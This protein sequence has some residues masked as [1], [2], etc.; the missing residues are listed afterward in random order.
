MG[1]SDLNLRRSTDLPGADMSQA[2]DL[3]VIDDLGLQILK[4]NG[5][6]KS[7]RAE[8]N[9]RLLAQRADLY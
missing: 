6:F 4:Q 9:R 3:L 1:P 8:F 2:F 7:R 5:D